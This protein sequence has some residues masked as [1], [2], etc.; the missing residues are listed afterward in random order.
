[1]SFDLRRN[2]RY[3]YSD[4]KVEYTVD[5]LSE[6]EMFDADLVNANEVGLCILSPRRLAVEQEITLINFMASS[7]RTAVVIWIAEYDEMNF[8]GKSDQVLYKVGLRFSA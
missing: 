8:F 2:E 5:H 4:Y 6:D 1:M 3:E 7:S